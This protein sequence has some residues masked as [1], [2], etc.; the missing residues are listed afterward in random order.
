MFVLSNNHKSSISVLKT[1]S[2]KTLFTILLSTLFTT[3]TIAQTETCDCKKDLDYLVKKM[4]K[5]PSYKNQI[6]GTDKEETFNMTY[7]NLA[8]K[9]NAP[10]AID[11]C[12]KMLPE[13]LAIVKDNHQNIYFNSPFFKSEYVSEAIKIS[14]FKNTAYYKNHPRTKEDLAQLEA[15]L[16]NLPA[17]SIE[18]IYTFRSKKDI[19]ALHKAANGNYIATLLK[20]DLPLWEPGQIVANVI[21]E[22]DGKFQVN[23]TNAKT[24]TPQSIKSMSFD[25][26]RLWVFKKLGNDNNNEFAPDDTPK[27]VFKNSSDTVDYVYFGS[28]SGSNTNRRKQKEFIKEFENKFNAP[29]LIVDLRSNGGGSYEVSDPFLKIF[30]KSGAN[31]YVITNLFTASNA[32]QFTTK[33][34]KNDKA[35]HLGQTTM[36]TITYG[37]E[38][39]VVTSPSGIFSYY[40][41]NMDF[42]KE[43]FKYEGVGVVP[44]QKL[45]FDRDWIAQTLDIISE[46]K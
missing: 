23:Y 3:I 24:F 22:S 20:T 10:L 38:N 25:N 43:Y 6:K 42:H 12:Y 34:L 16:L 39:S 14:E 7:E 2:M 9:M 4:K 28:F 15:R 27:W 40:V 21:P 36:G 5:T 37:M 17:T 46:N 41:T 35:T 32:E 33:I 19:I 29:N 13:Q 31:I 18:G 1:N 44:S 30:E 26:G 11:V 45:D 8:N